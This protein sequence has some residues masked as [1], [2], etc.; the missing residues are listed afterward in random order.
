M[1][2]MQEGLI[3]SVISLT[4]NTYWNMYSEVK[5]L[6]RIRLFLT[7]WT[8]AYQVPPSIGFSRQ[9]YWSW[10]PLPFPTSVLFRSYFYA[11]VGRCWE[12]G[13]KGVSCPFMS[14]SL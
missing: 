10:V 14:D 11:E 2:I 7:P 12:R 8:A 13:R 6:S 3:S 1:G 4:E 5:S 9:E